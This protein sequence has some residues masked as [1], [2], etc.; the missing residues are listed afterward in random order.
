[1]SPKP[2]TPP[3][4]NKPGTASTVYHIDVDLTSAAVAL[5]RSD[6]DV[7]ITLDMPSVDIGVPGLSGPQGVPGPTGLV[8]IEHGNDPNI[9]RPTGIPL[10]YWVGSVQPVHADPDDLLLLKGP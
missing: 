1:M 3:G 5:V 2:V 10:V 6:V 4:Q 7:Q 8:K 9:A